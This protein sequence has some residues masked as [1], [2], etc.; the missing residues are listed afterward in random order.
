[1]GKLIMSNN[2][3]TSVLEL[4]TI[5]RGALLA[6][7]PWVEKAKIKWK[8]GQAYDDWENISES[9]Y[10]NIVCSS[11]N[12]EVASEYRIARYNVIYDDYASINFIEVRNRNN[13][14]RKFAFVGFQSDFSPLDSVKVAE[15]DK[16]Y[17]VVNYNDLKFDGLEF[18]FVKNINGKKEII[19]GIEIA[20]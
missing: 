5:F 20:L 18:V 6:V 2:W 19:D 15:L 11:L 12:G 1:M 13:F 4:L 9:L 3:K 16:Y 7:I 10:K 17:K 14:Q 8:E